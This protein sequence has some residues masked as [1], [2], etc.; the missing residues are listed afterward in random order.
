MI[1]FDSPASRA[2]LGSALDAIIAIDAS[3]HVVEWNPAAERVFG[4]TRQ[5]ALSVRLSDL[6]IPPD[7]RPR[8]EAALRR[9]L[10]TGQSTILGRRIEIEALRSDGTRI[11]VELAVV[12]ATLQE[13]P[14]FVAFVRDITER[15]RTEAQLRES[16][17]RLRATY[18]HAFVGIAEVDQD[19]R[20]LRVNEHFCT[21]TGYSRDELL[22]RKFYSITHPDDT[23][24]DAE[25]FQ[26]QMRGEL[27]VYSHEKRYIRKDG[28]VV[29][30]ELEASVVNDES[31]AP[32]YGIRIVRDITE[33][34]LAQ[35]EHVRLGAIVECS[36]DAI[37]SFCPLGT[38]TTWNKGAE[39]LF[40]YTAQ[41][42]IGRNADLLVPRGLILPAPE[43]S[44]GMFDW[45]MAEGQVQVETIRQ[46]KDGSLVHVWATASRMEAPDGT[47]LGVS[48]IFRDITERKQAE[49]RQRIMMHELDHRV[50]NTLAIVQ[51]IASHTLRAA[52]VDR[53]VAAALTDR[54]IAL[55]G[56]HAIL[57]GEGWEGG[58]LD[59]LVVKVISAHERIRAQGPVVRLRPEFVVMLSLVLH[60]LATNAAKHGALSTETGQVDLTWTLAGDRL[61]L[62]WRE[63][64]GPPAAAP[65]RRGF[66]SQLIERLIRAQ[67]GAVLSTRYEPTGAEVDIQVPASSV[68]PT[69]AA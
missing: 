68:V 55:A 51:S 63:V 6:I 22:S 49:E 21:L 11:C 3:G 31:G 50:R 17:Q 46:C 44:R 26:R 39:A 19:G 35:A 34:K 12:A 47:P 30:V 56:A 54:L 7:L 58:D 9:V 2:L 38:V 15:K 53:S 64:G 33:R 60:E 23:P 57:S 14:V 69:T 5:E 4:Y 40:G 13:Q 18:E 32:L 65:S 24:Y 59:A 27:P 36:L 61:S 1:A 48:A 8:H 67:S 37:I 25:L 20:F 41:E 45:A 43:G 16:A 29:W 28:A 10:E 42:A 52:G 66:G 62:S